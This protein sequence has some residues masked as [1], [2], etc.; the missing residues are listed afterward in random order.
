MLTEQ[1]KEFRDTRFGWLQP[2]GTL[3]PCP[4]Y[5]HVSVLGSSPDLFDAVRAY[6]EEVESN[7]EAMNEALAMLGPDDHPEMHRFA[8]MNDDARAKLTRTAY[9]AGWIR[10][11][12]MYDRQAVPRDQARIRDFMQN[13]VFMLEAE[14]Y[15]QPIVAQKRLIKDLAAILDARVEARQMGM[16]TVRMTKRTQREMMLEKRTR[17]DLAKQGKLV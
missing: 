9:E 8:G 14:G 4:M 7:E 17:D 10:L 11:G 13:P 16:V 5:D 6:K 3:R 1:I 12:L 15:D 2:D